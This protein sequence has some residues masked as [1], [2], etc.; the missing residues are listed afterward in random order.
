MS[1]NDANAEDAVA[2]PLELSIGGI[3]EPLCGDTAR[4]ERQGKP[5]G[6]KCKN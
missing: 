6:W 5:I 2:L 1:S 3:S 4:L